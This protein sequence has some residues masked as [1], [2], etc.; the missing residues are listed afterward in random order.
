MGGVVEVDC[1]CDLL[2]LVIM[3]RVGPVYIFCFILTL[4]IFVIQD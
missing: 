2:N 4:H 1:E 3:H